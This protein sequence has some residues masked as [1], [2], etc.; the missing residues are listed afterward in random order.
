MFRLAFQVLPVLAKFYNSRAVDKRFQIGEQVIILDKGSNSKTFVRWQTGE[1]YQ[2]LSPY[3][4]IV[5][6]PNGK[7]RHL[8]A[9]KLQKLVV[10]AAEM[11][12][13]LCISYK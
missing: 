13:V 8:H 2:K 12:C 6:M 10:P 11:R 3:T 1:I 7:K 9:I 4:Y 5:S